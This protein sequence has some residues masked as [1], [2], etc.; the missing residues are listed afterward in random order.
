MDLCST[1]DE[2]VPSA[3]HR[4]VELDEKACGM[5]ELSEKWQYSVGWDD[6]TD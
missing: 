2:A 4:H 1:W 6:G 5:P 3:L